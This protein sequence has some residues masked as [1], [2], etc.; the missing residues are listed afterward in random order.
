M[1]LRLV[2]L[3]EAPGER[4]CAGR[5]YTPNTCVNVEMT[6]SA[7]RRSRGVDGSERPFEVIFL[8]EP[9]ESFFQGAF[10]GSCLQLPIRN[11]LSI[12]VYRRAQVDLLE[13]ALQSQGFTEVSRV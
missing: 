10:P 12:Q 11:Q 7:R 2:V 13:A 6:S 4:E 3:E 9:L 8:K 1:F 5:F